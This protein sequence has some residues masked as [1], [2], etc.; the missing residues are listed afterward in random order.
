MRVERKVVLITGASQGIGAGLVKGFLDR[1]YCFVANS[2]T[3]E[4][5][6]SPDL[7]TVAGDIADPETASRI[8]G[9]AIDSFGRVDTLVN[10]VGVFLSKPFVEYSE[11][12][13]AMMVRVNLAGSFRLS[14][15][16][17]KV[18]VISSISRRA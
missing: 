1:G 5:S 15:S 12:D 6:T 9:A 2:R 8:V 16:C 13:F 10:N 17:G 11:A 7:L 3:I 14:Q 18:A 4:P